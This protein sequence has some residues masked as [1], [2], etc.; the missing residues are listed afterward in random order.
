MRDSAK[1]PDEQRQIAMNE[2]LT[3]G[4]FTFYQSSFEDSPSG[5]KRSV[6]SVAYDPGRRLK[7]LGSLMICAGTLLMFLVRSKLLPSDPHSEAKPRA[8]AACQRAS[9]DRVHAT[10]EAV[11]L[12]AGAPSC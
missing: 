9:G 5:G 4:K 7:Y 10:R 12:E 3:V 6:L 11:S 2:P 8:D 1:G